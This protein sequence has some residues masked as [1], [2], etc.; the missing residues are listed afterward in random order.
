MANTN[1]KP[2]LS[3]NV[4]EPLLIVIIARFFRVS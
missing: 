3:T 2:Y 4:K 1:I